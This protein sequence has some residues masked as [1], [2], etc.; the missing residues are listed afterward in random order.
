MNIVFDTNIIFKDWYLRGPNI[1]LLEKFITLSNSILFIPKIVIEE[2]INRYKETIDMKVQS[3]QS[4]NGLQPSSINKI[5]NLDVRKIVDSYSKEFLARLNELKVIQPE[6][7]NIPHKKVVARDL[8]RKRPFQKS[9]K[10]YRDSLLW[11]NILNQIA[12]SQTKTFFISNNHTDFCNKD[13]K[14]LH[15]NLKEDLQEKGLYPDNVEICLNLDD[16]LNKYVKPDLISLKEAIPELLEGFH[17]NFDL[18]FWFVENKDSFKDSIQ[19]S[20]NNP[21][22]GIIDFDDLSVAYIED[23]DELKV[24]DVYEIDIDHVYIE[25]FA[26]T[27]IVLDVFVFKS[28][29]ILLEEKYDL[30]IWDNDWN[31]H[32]IYA[33]TLLK[34]PLDIKLELDIKNDIVQDYEISLCEY[35]GHCRHCFKPIMSDT[36]EVCPYCGKNLF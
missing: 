4:L 2:T 30:K 14:I 10:G 32:Y 24:D 12:S 16:F 11:E 1:S 35:Y 25:V 31:E 33:T 22:Y 29:F 27:D 23:P 18:H 28:D 20:L 5:Q 8:A 15:D 36:A 13:S 9:G 19:H 21:T 6:Y 34:L 26:L 17:G 3:I 7:S